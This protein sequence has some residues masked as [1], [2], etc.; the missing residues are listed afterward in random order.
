MAI[1]LVRV[2]PRSIIPTVKKMAVE[3]PICRNLDTLSLIEYLSR[4][5]QLNG[6][7]LNE[8]AMQAVRKTNEAKI[9]ADE[10]KPQHGGSMDQMDL[11]VT[12]DKKAVM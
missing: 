1:N 2:L 6:V 12:K 7:S 8:T 4:C 5:K 11:L 3:N 9:A 10:I